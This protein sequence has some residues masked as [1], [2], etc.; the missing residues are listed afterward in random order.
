M[1]LQ[2]TGTATTAN[3]LAYDAA[4]GWG[5]EIIRP[6]DVSRAGYG[7][8]GPFD[9]S[10]NGRAVFPDNTCP[11]ELY[12]SFIGAKTFVQACNEA[13]VGNPDDPCTSAGM[14]PE[15]II[16]RIDLPNGRYRFAGAFG[17]ADN[18]HVSRI[19]AEDGGSGGPEFIGTN[20]V[21][22]VSNFNQGNYAAGVFARV[23]FSCFNT[24]NGN[25]PRFVNMDQD[26]LPTNGP[27]A[28]PT[29]EVTQGYLRIHQLQGN[30]GTGSVRVSDPNGGNIVL[31][32]LWKVAEE[33]G[34]PPTVVRSLGP[35]PY[36]PGD[37]VT[38]TLAASDVSGPTTIADVFP[39][40]WTVADAGGG[41]VKQNTITFVRSTNGS[42][43]YTLTAPKDIGVTFTGT[44]KALVAGCDA[45]EGS[46]GGDILLSRAPPGDQPIAGAQGL[47]LGVPLIPGGQEEVSA[48]PRIVQVWASGADIWNAAD[49]GRMVSFGEYDRFDIRCI[50]TRLDALHPW[51]K[52]GL[53]ARTALSDP[54]SAYAF[55]CA[56]TANGTDFQYRDDLF[57]NA[58]NR[59]QSGPAGLLRELRLIRRTDSLI[60]AFARNPGEAKWQLF[61]TRDMPNLSTFVGVAVTSHDNNQ[62]A[63]ARFENVVIN[64]FPLE[65]MGMV[66]AL[67]CSLEA[68]KAKLTFTPPPNAASIG[69]Y[70]DKTPIADL[71]GNAT[72]YSDPTPVS[73]DTFY[74]VAAFDAEGLPGPSAACYGSCPPDAA[75]PASALVGA[76]AFGSR[77]LDCPTY[78]DPSQNYTIVFQGSPLDLQYDPGRGWG[79]EAYRPDDVS[80]AGYGIFG[81]FD[82]TAN[83]RNGFPDT[84]PEELYDSFIAPKTFTVNC[85]QTVVGNP[86][87]P[88][89]SAGLA[90]EGIIFR[91]DVPNGTYRFVAAV[92]SQDN[93]HAHRILA[94]DGGEGP[95]EFIQEQ[96]VVLVSNH[97]QAQTGAAVFARVGFDG[98]LPPLG[99]GVDPSPRF[100]NMDEDG[101]ATTGCPSSPT[102]EVT[103]GF[104]RVHQLQANSNNGPAGARDPNG[105]DLVILELWRIE[106]P[107]LPNPPR[108]LTAATGDQQ[109]DL[110]WNAPAPGPAFTAYTVWRNGAKI[111]ELPASTTTYSDLGLTNGVKFCYRVRATDG[112]LQSGDSNEA[113]ATPGSPNPPRNLVATAGNGK[114][115]LAWDEPAPGPAFT[116]Y[117]VLRDGFKVANV[118]AAQK[119]YEDS[120]LTNGTQ[121]CYRVRATDGVIESADSNQ[122]CAT[123]KAGDKN[124][125]RGDVD[126]NEALDINDAVTILSYLFLGTGTPNCLEAAD[127][128]NNGDVDI[129]DAVNN[130]GYQFLGQAPPA[131]PGAIDCGADPAT[132]FLGC[133]QPCP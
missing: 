85:D 120:G 88:C 45:Y 65:P 24:P 82:D 122:H 30:A 18:A 52:A 84:C 74:A 55:L 38:V 35:N 5:Y 126:A 10:P 43:A 67:V 119:T 111:A 27:A 17:S 1:V 4:R 99:D 108:D 40:G 14:L 63:G 62:L 9:D 37:T 128:D 54:S 79:Y 105:G 16:F 102:L 78:N 6:G 118:P 44:V 71:P 64:D 109:V 127:T 114:V 7:Q 98:K 29:L 94:E 20:Y 34:V 117:T 93:L 25:G 8:F 49:E 76:F 68:G 48:A 59:G 115:G 23:G 124:F 36:A 89:T 91:A 100:V 87:D 41:T 129:T 125:R 77:M 61:A 86:N 90:P 32:E 96:H 2:D 121:Y 104:I 46:I 116:G 80:R 26:G 56:T 107:D 75:A 19:L 28:S 69:I 53:M 112:V 113:C 33:A 83:N 70:R 12:D 106:T 31:L 123:P 81:P 92:G 110:A 97:D 50:V 103:Q 51:G 13:I 131:P 42:S 11:T 72:S 95:P 39:A 101:L 21:V 15:G 22:L 133:D 60:E 130:L 3:A 58:A 132:P 66:T 47:D 73:G 57:L